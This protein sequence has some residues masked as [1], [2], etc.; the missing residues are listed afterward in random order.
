MRH[1]DDV[2]ADLSLRPLAEFSLLET[3]RDA[4]ALF[5]DGGNAAPPG[6]DAAAFDYRYRADHLDRVS[7]LAACSGGRTIGLLF[8]ARRGTTTHISALAVAASA[9][10]QG[11][12]TALLR[13][14]VSEASQRG[15]TQ[16][17]SEVRAD[18]AGALALY[19]R[20]GF[21]RTRGLCG[22]SLTVQAPVVAAGTPIVKVDLSVAAA[23]V[24]AHG[25]L[26]LPW[27]YH[28]ATLF[29]CTAPARAYALEGRAYCIVAAKGDQLAIR[30]LV[31]DAD[32]RRRR[33]AT[34]LL[35]GVASL[36]RAS[37]ISTQ[38]LLPE[39]HCEEFFAAAGFEK[40]ATRHDELAV[41]L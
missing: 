27:F 28:P 20:C 23:A 4:M 11:V 12:A 39:G 9:R 22:Y 7:S 36:H 6:F 32:S 25:M 16:V 14:V 38:P 40:T 8:A 15:D 37:V 24:A 13:R 2:M 17:V 30:T 41:I 33:L 21:R 19:A 26:D 31:V 1:S 10:R 5:A 35:Q 29:G 18:E 34:R 3:M